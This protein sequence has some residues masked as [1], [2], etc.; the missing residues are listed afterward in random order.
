V[1]RSKPTAAGS[2][3][4]P[5][6]TVGRSRAGL[7]TLV[8]GLVVLTLAGCGSSHYEQVRKTWTRDRQAYEDLGAR[9]FATVTLKV[10]PF[11]RAYVDEYAR[12][13]A[14]TAEQ[15]EALLE[16]ELE[17]D[18]KDLVTVVSFYTPQ[19]SWNDLNPAR[20]IWEVRL[21]S[22]RGDYVAPYR[23]TRL[24]RRNPT[25]GALYPY[26]DPY[27]VLY[28]LRFERQL[29][30][31]RSIAGPGEELTLIIAGAP[32]QIRLSWVMP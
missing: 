15:R 19:P 31:G 28:E 11:R 8:V 23:V 20:G 1:R 6:R 24:D 27:H 13:F 5:P 18:K 21:E 22:A 12:L 4:L 25:W 16:N 29:P 2:A 17:E 30:D 3:S 32:T 9:A 26:V 10:E 7:T 14:L